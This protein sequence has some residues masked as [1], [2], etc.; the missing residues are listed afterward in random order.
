MITH[1]S[2]PKTIVTD[3]NIWL[4][5]AI[6][7]HPYHTN[8]LNLVQ[9]CATSEVRFI[10]PVLWE[11]EVDSGVRKMLL[12]H[13][14][15]EVVA[16]AALRWIDSASVESVHDSTIRFLARKIADITQAPRVYDATY[17]A[18]AYRMCCE[19]WTADQRFFNAITNAQTAASKR[20]LSVQVPQVRFIADYNGEYSKAK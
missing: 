14:I 10:V 18:F 7:A 6:S 2:I 9:H 19:L 20:H 13:Y 5:A 17:A 3:S 15:S 1:S 16:I 11:S 4:H 8:A 12:A